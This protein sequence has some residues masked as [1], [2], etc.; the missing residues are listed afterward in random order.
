MTSDNPRSR[1]RWRSSRT[2]FRK[3]FD[4]EIDPDRRGAIRRA[5]A[6][7][8][9]GDV[10]VIA[11]AG[12]EQ[13]QDVAGLVTPFDDREVAREALRDLGDRAPL[14][15]CSS[16]STS[17][18][19]ITGIEREVGPGDLFVAL[20]TRA[21]L[22]TTRGRAVRRRSSPANR[23]QH[24]HRLRRSSRGKTDARIVAVVVGKRRRR[25][26]SWAPSARRT[27]RRSGPRRA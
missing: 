14:G 5:I 12:H 24:S 8:E 25:R 9:E 11:G 4:V 18:A 17:A 13:G 3:R 6:L 15:S 2:C 20:N 23:R 22:S 27:R 1:S 7:A 10:V 19:L 16:R 26:T 21:G